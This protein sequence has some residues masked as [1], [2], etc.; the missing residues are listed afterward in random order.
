M[1]SITAA[2]TVMAA[3]FRGDGTAVYPEAKVTMKFGAETKPLWQSKLPS[4][5]NSSP[6]PVGDRLFVGA[7]P[8]LLFCLDA[9]NGTNLWQ[10]SL[11]YEETLPPE[12]RKEFEAQRKKEQEFN[13]LRQRA[14]DRLNDVVR[15][16][17]NAK[18]K[19]S[20]GG[21]TNKLAEIPGALL[22]LEAKFEPTPLVEKYKAPPTHGS[23]GF[24]TPSAVSDGKLVWVLGGNGVAACYSLDGQ[25]QWIRMVEKPT[26]GWGHSASPLLID[27][28]LIVAI[29]S[30]FAL[31]GQTGEIV[32]QAKS[33][34][35]FGTP[36]A[37]SIGG[38]PVLITTH[39]E[40]IDCA[41]GK[42]LAS[43]LGALAF[44]GPVVDK[45]VVYLANENEAK[46][47]RLPAAIAEPFTP[48]Q[49]WKA[50]APKARLYATPV[51]HDSLLYTFAENGMMFVLNA[52]TGEK[53][54][55][56]NLQMQ[57]TCYTSPTIVGQTLIVASEGGTMAAFEA[58]RD[59]KEI[60]RMKLDGLRSSPAIAGDRLYLRTLSGVSCYSLTGP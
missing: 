58:G 8:T 51:C 33:T 18:S 56:V 17:Q 24:S 10:A 36:A 59:L 43:N 27:G 39:G 46:A 23:N 14:L 57:G 38:K 2:G 41:N 42:I 4:W 21:L 19:E 9:G 1:M 6:L 49:L 20:F 54:K 11:A 32:W 30:V 3:G 29:N 31:N 28:K 52:A 37:A 48:T 7:E 26:T 16:V 47:Y 40:V 12:E 50:P 13:A 34:A 55:E 35:H 15:Q 5:S 44:N 22:E 60:G 25:R 53:L 45:D